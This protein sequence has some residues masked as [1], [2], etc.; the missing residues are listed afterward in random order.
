MKYGLIW[1]PKSANIGDDIQSYAAIRYLPQIDYIIN[2]EELDSFSTSNGESV[3]VIMN[4]W[5]LYE[6]YHWPPSPFLYPKI[7]GIH[8]DIFY[9]WK[10]YRRLNENHVLEGC[11]KKY[12]QTHGPIGCRDYGTL[13]MVQKAG[14]DAYYSGCLT[15]TLN[16]FENI[17][18]Q[19]YICLVDVP[20]P[21]LT[22]IKNTINRPFREISH[23]IDLQTLSYEQRTKK[24]ED[25]LKVYQGAHC[26]ITTRLH[27]ALP[28]LA[29]ETPVFLLYSD[30]M[31]NR[32]QTYLSYLNHVNI[33]HMESDV[34]ISSLY[35]LDNPPPNPT[36][37]MRE[38]LALVEECEQFI[39]EANDF[40]ISM[41]VLHSDYIE[42]VRSFEQY[43][44]QDSEK[45]QMQIENG[46]SVKTNS[47]QKEQ[48][49]LQMQQ[50]LEASFGAQTALQTELK[51]KNLQL[52]QLNE[53][54]I[55]LKNETNLQEKDLKWLRGTL[56]KIYSSRF[57]KIASKYYRFVEK[58]RIVKKKFIKR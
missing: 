13:G 29:L 1:Y 54:I 43:I 19:D 2:R 56:D 42:R 55:S 46:N 25:Y 57:W 31:E 45:L 32:V 23:Y 27:C 20:E 47:L 40:T 22:Q 12:L 58:F 24:V 50:Q 44:Q 30:W 18:R 3:A 28:C 36:V 16:K 33:D 14:V 8:F 52:T 15:L 26:V 53:V 21:Y 4:G 11:G 34:L 37:Y 5:Y 10:Y 39:R 9:S 38:R 51:E 7:L 41:P 6:H 35:D 17:D 48:E 49:L